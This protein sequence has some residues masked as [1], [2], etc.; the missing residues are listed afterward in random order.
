[1]AKSLLS[2]Q[3]MV[4]KRVTDLS[5]EELKV[6]NAKFGAP[7]SIEGYEFEAEE[8]FKAEALELGL[9]HNQALKLL[10]RTNSIKE[11]AAK[12]ADLTKET[13]LEDHA[14]A[15]EAEFG[16]RLEARIDLARKAALEL[17][18]EDLESSVFNSD[19][20]ADLK[21]IKALSEAGKRLF[22]HE[23]VA[24][25]QVTQF[26]LTPSE[27][28]NEIALLKSNPEFKAAYTGRDDAARKAATNK[29]SKLYEVAYPSK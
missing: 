3:E 8:A 15:L 29:L 16:S 17:G 6:I 20:P 25:N 12:E 2:A 26:G 28:I 19:N 24:T 23:S 1:M 18:G 9:N 22:D 11:A 27:A 14:R 10:E 21:I 13:R 4:G 7:E 5:A